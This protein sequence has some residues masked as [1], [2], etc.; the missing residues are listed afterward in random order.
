MVRS[1][2]SKKQQALAAE[3]AWLA[4]ML[5]KFFVQTRPKW[6]RSVLFPDLEGE[7]M[8]AITRAARTYDPKR[9]PYPK[10]YFVRAIMNAQNKWI[11][12]ADRKPADWLV[13]MQEAEEA[14]VRI[15]HPDYLTL[16]IED[17]PEEDRAIAEDRFLRGQTL[18]SISEGHDLSLRAASLRARTLARHIARG[19]DIQL[20]LPVQANARKRCDSTPKSFSSS[21]ASASTS[22]RK[23]SP[24]N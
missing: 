12:K 1:K 4:T 3:W 6:Q 8:I 14:T 19:L 13:S 24:T 9:L 10:A 7:G 21:P 18:R 20:P 5:A 2:L 15:E 11:K 16:A 23:Q 22:K 17:L